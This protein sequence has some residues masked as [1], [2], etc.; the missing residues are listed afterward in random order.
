MTATL[1]PRPGPTEYAEFYA[2]YIAQVP[3][4]NLVDLLATQIDD[5]VGLLKPLSPAEA[6]FRYAPGKW[7]VIEVVGHMAD[8]E[9]VMSYRALRFARRDTTPL[10]G[11][12]ENEWVPA[13]DFE[14]RSLDDVVS[15]L[16]AVRSATV[17]LF[18]SFD[19]EAWS[20]RGVANGKEVSV[21]AL[22]FV[23]AGHERH[24]VALLRDRYRIGGASL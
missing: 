24:H 19:E 22:G 10:P 20:R 23:I 14:R 4:G 16:R 15:E 18:R 1:T 6:R 17:S 12:D 8:G 9:R 7:S 11:F 21:R 2:G 13:A 3:E 5:T